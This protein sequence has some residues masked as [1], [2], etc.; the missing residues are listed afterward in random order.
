MTEKSLC[1]VMGRT[2]ARS[3]FKNIRSAIGIVINDI[4]L[5]LGS[6]FR[7][8]SIVYILLRI[9]LSLCDFTYLP[10]QARSSEKRV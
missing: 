4:R 7:L 10:R 1:K 6:V 3:F 2:K 8:L 9:V 5:L